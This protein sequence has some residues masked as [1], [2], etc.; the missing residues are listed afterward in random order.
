MNQEKE[1]HWQLEITLRF[2]YLHNYKGNIVILQW[3]GW[4]WKCL[5]ANV[6]KKECQVNEPFWIAIDKTSLLCHRLRDM[7]VLRR[8]ETKLSRQWPHFFY[9]E[10]TENQHY[11]KMTLLWTGQ[12]QAPMQMNWRRLLLRTKDVLEELAV[13]NLAQL[14]GKVKGGGM[15]LYLPQK[16]FTNKKVS[17]Y[18]QMY[19]I[20][21]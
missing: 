13:L 3:E 1:V 16:A 5:L 14:Y 2:V 19:L 12:S 20:F 4:C 6:K 7:D 17:L 10:A 21:Q 8:A 15:N 9:V 11:C 18:E